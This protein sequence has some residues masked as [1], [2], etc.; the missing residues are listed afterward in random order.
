MEIFVY[1]TATDFITK[2]GPRLEADEARYGLIS[3]IARQVAV[4]PHYY[5]IDDPWFCSVNNKTNI[6]AAAWRTPPY[7]VGMALF[8]GNQAVIADCL[9]QA[10][11]DRWPVI[12]GAIGDRDLVEPF[13]DGWCRFTGAS[14]K[15]SMAQRIYRLD[16]IN[17]LALI[18]GGL[19][20]ATRDDLDLVTTWTKAFYL[21]TF[22]MADDSIPEFEITPKITSGDVY[23]WE[24]DRPVSM[25]AKCRPTDHGLAVGYVYT[26]PEYRHR[27]YATACVARVCR[28][29]L[30]DGYRFCTLY[31]D[32]ANPTSNSIYQKIGFRP[33]GDSVDY[34]LSKPAI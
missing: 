21:D 16:K 12:P 22:G 11:Y 28:E 5:G 19:R 3:G 24:D 10:I 25:A 6:C 32:L 26:P 30:N 20:P 2:V 33:V 13:I 27:G 18:P 14:I 7:N 4:N 15:S 23:I 31:A 29:I 1:Q 34:T 9:T 8:S 17:N